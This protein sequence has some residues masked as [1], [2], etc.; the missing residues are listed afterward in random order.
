VITGSA[1]HTAAIWDARSGLRLS[2]LVGH[3][4]AVNEATFNATGDQAVTAG[5][6]QSVIVWGVDLE[7]RGPKDV[8]KLVGCYI[9]W[10]VDGG[11]L[12]EARPDPSPCR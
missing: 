11:E 9:P 12:V 6:G 8:D 3:S 7:S 5:E 10:K 4:G 1:D 2:S